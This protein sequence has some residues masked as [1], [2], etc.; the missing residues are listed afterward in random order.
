M[1]DIKVWIKI[2]LKETHNSI[3][4]LEIIIRA[5][6]KNIQWRILK[7]S[8]WTLN[9][10]DLLVGKEAQVWHPQRVIE[11]VKQ[12]KIQEQRQNQLLRVGLKQAHLDLKKEIQIKPIIL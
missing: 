5:S 7:N 4:H 2:R 9:L 6:Q 3:C 11:K 10:R 1:K 8:Q 12:W